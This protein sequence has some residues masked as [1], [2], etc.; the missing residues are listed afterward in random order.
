MDHPRRRLPGEL[1]FVL[2]LLLFA[3]T[4][5]WQAWRISAMSGWSTPGAL[6]TLAALVMLLSGIRIAINTLRT[7]PPEVEPGRS[8]A[9]DFLHQITPASIVL[10]TVLIVAYMFALEPL[11]FVAS[12]FMFLALAM[13]ALGERRI[14][15]TLAVSAVS[16]AG[17]YIVFQTAFSVVLPEGILNGLLP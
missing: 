12:S 9:R 11:G 1:A 14:L 10:F 3:L 16:L 7:P 2:I 15:R 4:A 13:F 17:I 8:L 6:P 5:L